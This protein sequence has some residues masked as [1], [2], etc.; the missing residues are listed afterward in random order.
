MAI[1]W[2]IGLG[3]FVLPNMSSPYADRNYSVFS[4]ACQSKRWL[5]GAPR[6][7]R[8]RTLRCRSQIC[9]LTSRKILLPRLKRNSATAQPHDLEKCPPFLHCDCTICWLIVVGTLGTVGFFR[10]KESCY[11]W[12]LCW[13]VAYRWCS[14]YDNA[15]FSAI[16]AWEGYKVWERLDTRGAKRNMGEGV[17]IPIILKFA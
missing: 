8:H 2:R 16:G 11:R 1:I 9:T 14:L 13:Y 6:C 15:H 10:G 5:I 12:P 17:Y 3:K 7:S 4:G